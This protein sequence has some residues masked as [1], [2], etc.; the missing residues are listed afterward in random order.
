MFKSVKDAFRDFNTIA[1]HKYS[2]YML[3]IGNRIG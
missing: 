2:I 1:L 3:D